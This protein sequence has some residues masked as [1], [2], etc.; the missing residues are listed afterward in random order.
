MK[1]LIKKNFK[2]NLDSGLY[3]L[4]EIKKK[5]NIETDALEKILKELAVHLKQT[6]EF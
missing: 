1:K 3:I 5:L 6:K 2:H 4:N